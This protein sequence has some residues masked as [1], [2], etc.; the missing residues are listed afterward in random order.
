MN[1]RRLARLV[2]EVLAP[3]P[4]AATLLLL[5]A[6]HSTSSLLEAAWWGFL[7]VLF[8]VL[9]PF[10]YLLYG[11]RRRR[12]TDH[13]VRLRQQRP[14]P[15]GVAVVSVVVD[16][17]LLLIFGAPRELL[18]LVVAMAVGLGISTLVT[19]FWKISI[20]VAVV[21]GAVVILVLVFRPALLLLAPVVLLVA[22]ARVD[23]GDHTV[24]QVAAGA[25]IG[26]LVAATVFSVLR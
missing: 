14:L 11:V 23:L 15:L 20:H 24:R 12:F 17:V 4:V 2:T 5:I 13:H 9:I 10:L 6:W 18:A 26:A 21:A 8:T 22:W 3:A 19:L 25:V 16:V 1:Q 7:T